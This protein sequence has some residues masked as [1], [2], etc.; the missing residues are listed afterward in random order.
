MIIIKP[1]YGQ[2]FDVMIGEETSKIH[3]RAWK[4][5]SLIILDKLLL[6]LPYWMSKSSPTKL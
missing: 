5:G 3:F 2:G 6:I 1:Y 4:R